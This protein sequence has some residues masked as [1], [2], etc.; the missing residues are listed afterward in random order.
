M[1]Q[2]E[3]KESIGEVYVADEVVSAV[4]AY[5]AMETEGVADLT[6]YSKWAD[7]LNINPRLYPRGVK[8]NIQ[9]SDVAV[10]LTVRVKYGYSIPKVTKAVQERVV[11]S[12][13]NMIGLHVTQVNIRV[14]GV[15]QDTAAR[16]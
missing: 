1:A 2:A 6:S 9:G 14:A 15:N 13:Q 5:A 10:A 4:A 8:I 11:N 7:S 3:E 12:I 16:A